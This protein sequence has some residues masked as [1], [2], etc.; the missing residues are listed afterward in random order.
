MWERQDV[1]R[2]FRGEKPRI[3]PHRELSAVVEADQGTIVKS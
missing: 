1:K 3:L 2:A